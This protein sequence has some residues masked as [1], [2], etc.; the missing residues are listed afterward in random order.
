MSILGFPCC[1]FQCPENCLRKSPWVL[2]TLAQGSS[3][4]GVNNRSQVGVSLHNTPVTVSG[5]FPG[6]NDR[7]LGRAAGI[8]MTTTIALLN[9]SLLAPESSFTAFLAAVLL[10]G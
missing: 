10:R 4:L 8:N 6:A 2:R 9:H 7:G 5:F 1:P 3:G